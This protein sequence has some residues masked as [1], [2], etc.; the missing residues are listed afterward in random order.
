M[1]KP[2]SRDELEG[3]MIHEAA[4]DASGRF[5]RYLV[6]KFSS[7]VA[8]R[9][10]LPPS[11]MAAPGPNDNPLDNLGV[12][13]FV[14]RLVDWPIEVL[15]RFDWAAVPVIASGRGKL[16]RDEQWFKD[17][18]NAGV[19]LV[20]WDWLPPSGHLK[21]SPGL[22]DA[23]RW[24]AEQGAACFMSDPEREWYGKRDEAKLYVGASQFAA[25]EA[26]IALGVTSY[27][28][29]SKRWPSDVFVPGLPDLCVPQP[30][31]RFGEF[32][33]GYAERSLEAYRRKGAERLVL[34]RGAF[35]L[36]RPH[37][38]PGPQRARARWRYPA[39]IRAHIATIPARAADVAGEIW[40]PPR[41]EAPKGVVQAIVS[42]RSN[43][44]LRRGA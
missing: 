14:R 21:W 16:N 20:A 42:G 12:G 11:C 37:D 36:V 31:D 32:A 23:I 41:G 18:R 5:D 26:G 43:R 33:P 3:A 29:P 1:K 27:A 38:Q 40:W 8:D 10:G 7:A 2:I 24:S 25:R 15:A 34:G 9:L 13:I 22:G 35:Q 39:E 28:L 30:Y 6:K 17:A 44:E 19:T 4:G